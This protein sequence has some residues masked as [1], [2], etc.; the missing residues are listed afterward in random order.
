MNSDLI[1]VE[2]NHIQL[3]MQHCHFATL[4]RCT[5]HLW[6]FEVSISCVLFLISNL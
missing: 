1:S 4:A 5:E 3:Y 2:S 6:P